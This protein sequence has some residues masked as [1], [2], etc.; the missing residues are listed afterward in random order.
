M[1]WTHAWRSRLVA[2]CA[3]LTALRPIATHSSEIQ[4]LF[5]QPN[6]PYPANVNPDQKVLTGTMR[7]AWASFAAT[8]TRQSLYFRGRRS[9]S[10]GPSCR[11]R[12][13]TR[14]CKPTSGHFTTATFGPPVNHHRTNTHQGA[15]HEHN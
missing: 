2:L 1:K 15:S 3:T 6:I 12:F 7:Q 11:S 4:Y 13:R 8:G 9:A 10:M 14:C 5:D